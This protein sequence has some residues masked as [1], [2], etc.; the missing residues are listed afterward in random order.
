MMIGG[1]NVVLIG[2]TGSVEV[3]AVLDLE[4]VLRLYLWMPPM[5]VIL[6]SCMEVDSMPMQARISTKQTK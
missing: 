2:G 5:L 6:H 1:G 3:E 4:V